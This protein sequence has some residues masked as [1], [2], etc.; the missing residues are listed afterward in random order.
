MRRVPLV[1]GVP[2]LVSAVASGLRDS[3]RKLVLDDGLLLAGALAFFMALSLAPLVLLVAAS[4]SSILDAAAVKAEV[5]QNART[6]LGPENA[7]LVEAVVGRIEQGGDLRSFLAGAAGLLFGAT[8]VF[9]QLRTT[10]NR[11]WG[12]P[13]AEGPLTL[14]LIGERLTAL[15]VVLAL[16]LLHVVSALLTIVLRSLETWT[17]AL[18][19]GELHDRLPER[20]HALLHAPWALLDRALSPAAAALVLTAVFALLSDARVRWRDAALG[21]VVTTLL[22]TAGNQLLGLTVGH[23]GIG[24]AFGAGSVVFVL[25]VWLYASSLALIFGAEV[26]WVRAHR[27][28]APIVPEAEDHWRAR[29]HRQRW[30]GPRRSPAPR[31]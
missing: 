30:R 21:A 27:A 14:R 11:L 18:V 1:V 4:A 25:L 8:T 19:P 12:I 24:S 17:H 22:V 13:R 16:G 31:P 29:W 7:R 9:V 20:V 2:R 28:G 23:L 3:A 10:L 26:T 5:L 15:L 6:L